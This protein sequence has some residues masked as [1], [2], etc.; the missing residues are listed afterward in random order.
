MAEQ[1]EVKQDAVEP[2]LAE[3]SA[4]KQPVEVEPVETLGQQ[5]SEAAQPKMRMDETADPGEVLGA[6]PLAPITEQPEGPE[7]DRGWVA[8]ADVQAVLDRGYVQLRAVEGQDRFVGDTKGDSKAISKAGFTGVIHRADLDSLLDKLQDYY[9]IGYKMSNRPGESGAE[10]AGRLAPV[11]EQPVGFGANM[12]P[13]GRSADPDPLEPPQGVNS[14][15]QRPQDPADRH[16]EPQGTVEPD[17]DGE[18]GDDDGEPE[19]LPD[20][21]QEFVDFFSREVLTAFLEETGYGVNDISSLYDEGSA[22][23]GVD[24]GGEEWLGFSDYS[25]A[26]AAATNQVERDL[27]DEPGIFNQDWL[28]GFV[29][30]SPTDQGLL[31]ND[32]ADSAVEGYSDED[33]VRDAERLDVTSWTKY[34]NLQDERD[35][36]DVDDED[37]EGKDDELAG[38]QDDMI[39]D[40]KEEVSSALSDEYEDAIAAEPVK[41]FVDDH[42]LFTRE[43]FFDADFVS[44][45]VE[46]AADSAVDT[47][48]VAHFLAGYDGEEHEVNDTYWYRQN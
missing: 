22:G 35:A 3:A 10:G 41:F 28:I 48:G 33:V 36:L 5:M 47:D 8:D 31:A 29:T 20:A 23:V 12:G 6:G 46:A 18:G 24:I 16:M 21:A 38:Q 25:A 39:D 37:D 42:G 32:M 1:D 26:E 14:P 27:K 34:A 11:T 45:D 2:S 44:I 43:Q 9:S 7:G 40:M 15:S 30:I 17:I 4:P 13:V 19:G